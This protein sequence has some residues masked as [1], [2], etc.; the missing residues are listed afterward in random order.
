MGSKPMEQTVARVLGSLG[1]TGQ[2][3]T[4]RQAIDKIHAELRLVDYDVADLAR[5]QKI[6][7]E[8]SVTAQMKHNLNDRDAG[9]IRAD[10]P[11]R[12][13]REFRTIPAW[14]C[15][16]EQGDRN[17]L[18]LMTQQAGPRDWLANAKLK[19]GKS[20]QTKKAAQASQMMADF[21]ENNS[22]NCLGDLTPPPLAAE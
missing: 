11:N 19:M 9:A 6:V 7:I 4:K 10:L 13:C 18:W 17:A 8:E 15:V 16:S 1:M 22:L 14:I 3:I 20:K 2:P 21:L 5:A 12:L